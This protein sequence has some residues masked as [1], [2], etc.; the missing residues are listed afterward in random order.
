MFFAFVLLTYYFLGVLSTM[1]IV[2]KAMSV[3]TQMALLHVVA[4]YRLILGH[5]V[6]KRHMQAPFEPVL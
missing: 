5:H 3:L 1:G 2:Q 4:A 6:L